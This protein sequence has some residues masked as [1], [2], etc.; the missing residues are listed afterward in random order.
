MSI[1][2]QSLQTFVA[3]AECGN[4]ADAAARLH[5]TP[6]AVSMTLKQLEAHFGRR[7]FEAD[8]KAQLT[9]L[10]QFVL[11]QAREELEHFGETLR[12]MQRYANGEA[13]SLRVACV[14]SVATRLLPAVLRRFRERH[15]GVYVD[16]RDMDSESVGDN[17]RRGRIDLGIASPAASGEG[18]EHWP[19]LR[20]P[21]GV[22]C[23][24][25][26]P[27]ARRRRRLRW[28]DLAGHEF[29]ANGTC[30]AIADAELQALM[31]GSSLLVR[32]TTSLVAL[33]AANAGITV[34]PRLAVD[35]RD[36]AVRFRALE[37]PV[38][39]RELVVL[40][41]AGITPTPAMEA[42]EVALAGV[43]RTLRAQVSEGVTAPQPHSARRA[44]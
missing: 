22:V 12:A 3:V 34:L 38:P 44:P 24:A 8:R 13:G 43:A 14:P 2:I 17:L 33:V 15:A 5:R 41:R 4:L 11:Q 6:S 16:V 19:L 29:I 26:H 32:N 42:F 37:R 25:G 27:L 31:E 18:F 35:E 30:R 1:K 28:R 39:F 40:R 9:P 23:S 20:D 36:G 10:G 7:L 21:F